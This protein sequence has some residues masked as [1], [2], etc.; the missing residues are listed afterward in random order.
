MKTLDEKQRKDLTQSVY[1][2]I[3]EQLIPDL[4]EDRTLTESDVNVVKMMASVC[5]AAA[6]AVLS[7]LSDLEEAERRPPDRLKS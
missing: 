7:F 6:P 4:E 1:R 3:I 5:A 2:S